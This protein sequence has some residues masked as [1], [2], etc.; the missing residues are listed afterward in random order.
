LDILRER[1]KVKGSPTIITTTSSTTT[2]TTSTATTTT[3]VT[4][5]TSKIVTKE[6]KDH[7]TSH[8]RPKQPLESSKVPSTTQ[9]ADVKVVHPSYGDFEESV[10]VQEDHVGSDEEKD[11]IVRNNNADA[12]VPDDST[13]SVIHDITGTTV[14]VVGVI[15]IIPAAG[16]VAWVV[17]YVVKKRGLANSENGS[18]TGLNCPISDD[19]MIQVNQAKYANETSVAPVNKRKSVCLEDESIEDPLFAAQVSDYYYINLVS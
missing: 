19:D 17:R 10:L 16:L 6:P 13:D 14:Y 12:Q 7:P 2:T 1:K 18:E 9:K 3:T 8:L 5:T 4:S 11:R 15:C